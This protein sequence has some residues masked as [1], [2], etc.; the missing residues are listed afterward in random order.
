MA[1]AGIPRQAAP[2]PGPRV[3]RPRGRSTVL[4][5]QCNGLKWLW[6]V[7]AGCLAFASAW[8]VSVRRP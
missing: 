2:K 7:I 3:L 5:Q 4:S 6:V 8:K 1:C